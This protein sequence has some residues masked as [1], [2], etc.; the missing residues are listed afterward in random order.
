MR[1]SRRE[2]LLHARMGASVV[3]K[4]VQEKGGEEKME[5]MKNGARKLRIK[6]L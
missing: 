1:K 5:E 2:G 4:K 6:Q 3:S